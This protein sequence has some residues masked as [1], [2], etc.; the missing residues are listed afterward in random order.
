MESE[1]HLRPSRLPGGLRYQSMTLCLNGATSSFYTFQ[2]SPQQKVPSILSVNMPPNIC[3]IEYMSRKP[4]VMCIRG[5]LAI[6]I[7]PCD[8]MFG[9]LVIWDELVPCLI[10]S[11]LG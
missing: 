6:T 9:L 10:I 11:E 5:I 7:L 2:K 1:C 3:L 8:A 4:V